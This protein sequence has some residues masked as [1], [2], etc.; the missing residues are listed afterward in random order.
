MQMMKKMGTSSH[1]AGGVKGGGMCGQFT[2]ATGENR[3]GF[4]YTSGLEQHM[5]CPGPKQPDHEP[6]SAYGRNVKAASGE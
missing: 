2:R 3:R 5:G 1:L 6:T 4:S